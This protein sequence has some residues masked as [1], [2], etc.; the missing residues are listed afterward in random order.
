MTNTELMHGLVEYKATLEDRPG[1]ANIVQLVIDI[2][3]DDIEK[4]D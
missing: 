2:I 3:V 4:G 1:I